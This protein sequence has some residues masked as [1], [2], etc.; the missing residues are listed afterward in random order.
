MSFAVRW[1]PAALRDLED[2]GNDA[3]D[4]LLNVIAAKKEFPQSGI[5]LLY[6]GRFTGFWSVNF[7]AYKAFYRVRGGSIEVARVLLCKRDYMRV[8]FGLPSREAPDDDD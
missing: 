6:K 3:I 2:A 5:P 4:D 7:K 1:S 8:L